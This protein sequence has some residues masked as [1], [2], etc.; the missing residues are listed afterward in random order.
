MSSDS[1]STPDYYPDPDVISDSDSGDEVIFSA[2]LDDARVL[3]EHCER[4]QPLTR[5]PHRQRDRVGAHEWLMQDYLSPDATF[6]AEQFRRRFRLSRQLF[7]R[8]VGDLERDYAFFQQQDDA[9]GKPGYS[10][11]QKCTTAIRQ[12]AYGTT[13][14]AMEEYLQMSETMARE[15]LH[16]FCECEKPTQADIQKIY[17]VHEQRHGF[18]GMLG[19]LDCTHWAWEACPVAWQGQYHRGD[20]DEPTVIVEAAA[21]FELWIWHVFFGMPDVNNDIAVINVSPLFDRLVNGVGPDTSFFTNGINYECK[22]YLVDGIYPDWATLVHSFTCRLM[23]NKNIT[24]KNMSRPERTSKG[25][26]GY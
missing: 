14:D 16:T 13:S 10:P 8:I 15:A 20:H 4:S 6:D 24:R 9:R 3:V 11:L 21:S 1:S 22:Y 5:R 26:L 18:P 17:E 23:I 2:I 25:N 19:S 7:L 12:L